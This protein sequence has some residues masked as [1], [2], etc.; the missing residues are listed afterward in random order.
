MWIERTTFRTAYPL[1]GILRWF[2][3]TSTETVRRGLGAAG[4]SQDP[5]GHS[6]QPSGAQA[7]AWGPCPACAMLCGQQGHRV[8]GAAEALEW[9]Q[10]LLPRLCA[11][12]LFLC[13]RRVL[14][15]HPGSLRSHGSDVMC[16]GWAVTGCCRHKDVWLHECCMSA[17]HVC[18][19]A[20]AVHLTLAQLH[21]QSDTGGYP[22]SLQPHCCLVPMGLMLC[23]EQGP[24][25]SAH[26]HEL[27][28]SPRHP[29]PGV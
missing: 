29:V 17:P 3:V 28:L 24:A 13:Q 15:H 12:A 5:G 4:P 22:G 8:W 9:G 16:P 21:P 7:G 25:W 2:V 1:P 14:G 26:P 18:R 11:W 19:G 23:W 20:Q 10:Q 27:S 6:L